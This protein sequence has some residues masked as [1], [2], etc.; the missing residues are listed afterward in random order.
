MVSSPKASRPCTQPPQLP[1]LEVVGTAYEKK[2]QTCTKA[3]DVGSIPVPVPHPKSEK[4]KAKAASPRL[5]FLARI[6]NK[7]APDRTTNGL[8]I[9]IPSKGGGTISSTRET[10]TKGTGAAFGGATTPKTSTTPTAAAAA[11]P[12]G[13]STYTTPGTPSPSSATSDRNASSAARTPS[14]LDRQP[15]YLWSHQ[16]TKHKNFVPKER[17]TVELGILRAKNKTTAFNQKAVGQ[18]VELNSASINGSSASLGEA[19]ISNTPRSGKS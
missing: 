10:Y 16:T 18:N 6:P 11:S 8:K 12:V 17:E 7:P 1:A 13:T 5:D 2:E 9:K 3:I 14:L 4:S 19:M 15:S